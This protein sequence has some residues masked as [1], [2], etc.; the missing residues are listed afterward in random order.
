MWGKKWLRLCVNVALGP[1]DGLR[2]TCEDWRWI[3]SHLHEFSNIFQWA[4]TGD[5]QDLQ[6]GRLQR[7]LRKC[8]GHLCCSK[9]VWNEDGECVT[10]RWEVITGS[11]NAADY[12]NFTGHSLVGHHILYHLRHCDTLTLANESRSV[13]S[14]NVHLELWCS[15]TAA[16]RVL[17]AMMRCSQMASGCCSLCSES[18]QQSLCLSWQIVTLCVS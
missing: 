7:L 12:V 1:S 8:Q 14:S 5:A 4:A 6:P 11:S 17:L 18:L 15:G 2:L 10:L 3:T 9:R 16:K 13:W